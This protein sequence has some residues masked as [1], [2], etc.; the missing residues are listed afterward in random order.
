MDKSNSTKGGRHPFPVWF[1]WFV[2]IML[3]AAIV[4]GGFWVR[5][6]LIDTAPQNKR[7]PKGE[8]T[9]VVEVKPLRR[10]SRRVTLSAMGTVIPICELDLRSRVNGEV[11]EMSPSLEPG[12]RLNA[13]DMVLRLDTDDY[14]LALSR[15]Q[16]ALRDVEAQSSEL[17]LQEKNYVDSLEIAKSAVKLGEEELGRKASLVRGDSISK[18]ARDAEE[19][20]VLSL[21]AQVQSIENSLRL[22][23]SRRAVTQAKLE[24]AKDLVAQARLD[25]ERTT[26]R[27]PFNAVVI[28]RSATIGAQVTAQTSLARLVDADAFHVET[29]IRMSRLNWIALPANGKPGANVIVRPSGANHLDSQYKGEVV[30]LQASLEKG[31]RLARILVKV[32]D[33]LDASATPLLLD[34]FVNVEIEGPLLEDVFVLPGD[35]VRGGGDVWLLT[36]EGRLDV[37]RVTSAWSDGESVIVRGGLKEGERL[38]LSDIA[39][40]VPGM[41]LSLPDE[42]RKAMSAKGAGPGKGGPVKGGPG[43]GGQGKRAGAESGGKAGA[44]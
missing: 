23:P 39:S 26:I 41:K 42:A 12:G 15:A 37:R 4:Y 1:I 3:A 29:P 44:R 2:R 38:I 18:S 31:G 43:K 11:V 16:A 34:S 10:E 35:T 24:Q 40:P 21:R 28:E 14:E 8:R 36:S 30:R 7:R 17:D 33:P 19:R 22:L 27:C 32:E 13:G 5:Q 20:T 9:A 25:L 6:R